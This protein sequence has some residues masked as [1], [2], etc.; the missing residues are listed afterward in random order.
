MQH[1]VQEQFTGWKRGCRGIDLCR[2]VMYPAAPRDWGTRYR[3]DPYT[4][5]GIGRM[6]QFKYWDYAF[7][8]CIQRGYEYG[9]LP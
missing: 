2:Y 7:R 9:K 1:H 4:K 6:S 5:E 8:K 3:K